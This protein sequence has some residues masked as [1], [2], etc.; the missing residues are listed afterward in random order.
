MPIYKLAAPEAWLLIINDHFL[1]PGEVRTNLDELAGW[2]FNSDFDKVLLFLR[3]AAGR[4]DVI[5]LGR[6]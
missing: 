5:E 3:D 2:T 4:G 6:T 1:G